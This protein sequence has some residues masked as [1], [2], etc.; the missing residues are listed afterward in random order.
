MRGRHVVGVGAAAIADH[1]GIDPRPARL[2]ML[3]PSPA[4]R[5]RA[6]SLITKP[7]RFRSNGRHA[8]SRVLIV[9]AQ[10][11]HIV[12]AGDNQRQDSR[13]RAAG[14][15]G[16][17]IAASQHLKRLTHCSRSRS[18][19][20]DHCMIRAVYAQLNGDS[21]RRRCPASMFG[22][23]NGLVQ[24]NP[25]SAARRSFSRMLPMPPM[26]VPTITPTRSASGPRAYA[27]CAS[28][29][30]C[31]RGRQRKLNVAVQLASF[32]AI[33]IV[34]RA[35]SRAPRPR[36]VNAVRSGRNAKCDR[37][38]PCPQPAHPTC[39]PHSDQPALSRPAR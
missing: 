22:I 8:R 5:P 38:P 31:L 25:L 29:T 30:A 33:H 20:A 23:R 12:K 28:A 16:V 19:G 35:R 17:G 15:H 7:S 26:P 6:P 4:R 2:G 18:A 37:C 34:G 39:R 24:R 27:S 9:P 13:L 14:D 10:R 36:S 21:C 11:A 32:L 3:L 1:F